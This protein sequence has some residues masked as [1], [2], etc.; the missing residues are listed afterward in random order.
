MTD[1]QTKTTTLR[2]V[3]VELPFV[4]NEFQ[5]VRVPPK[6]PILDKEFRKMP[7]AQQQ[8]L[9]VRLIDKVKDI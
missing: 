2:E 3:H 4:V 6:G 7:C 9:M 8:K 5:R 1:L